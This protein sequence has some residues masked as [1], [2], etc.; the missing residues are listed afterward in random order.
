VAAT[1]CVTVCLVLLVSPYLYT[2]DLVGYSLVVAM[3][4]ERQP[5]SAVPLLLWLCPGVSDIFVILTGVQ[6]LP[7]CMVAVAALAWREFGGRVDGPS[8]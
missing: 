2:S 5:W 7:L 4:A 1:A 8:G 3:V 6:V